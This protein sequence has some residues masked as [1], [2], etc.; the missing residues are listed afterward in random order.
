[1]T[2][3]NSEFNF[4]KYEVAEVKVIH[5]DNHYNFLY[6]LSTVLQTEKCAK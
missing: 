5:Y 4:N 3:Q 1:M 2:Y 6:R